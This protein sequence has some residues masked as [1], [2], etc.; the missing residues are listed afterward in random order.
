MLSLVVGS[1]LGFNI[2]PH[3]AVAPARAAVSMNFFDDM[4]DMFQG[5]FGKK[6]MPTLEEAE[7]YCMDDES[8]GC[9]VDMCARNRERPLPIRF[10]RTAILTSSCVLAQAGHAREEQA[11]G[12]AQAQAPLVGRD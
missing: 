1:S 11:E 3:A 9:T 4:S 7:M 10:P 5:A 2:V 12:G 6:S 8:S